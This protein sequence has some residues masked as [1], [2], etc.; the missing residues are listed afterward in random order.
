VAAGLSLGGC[1]DETTT[2]TTP[3]PKADGPKELKRPPHPNMATPAWGEK[4]LE[5]LA[6]KAPEDLTEKGHQGA[7]DAALAQLHAID[8]DSEVL[9]RNAAVAAWRTAMDDASKGVSSALAAAAM[10]LEPTLDG[11]Q[12]RLT[13]AHGIAAYAGTL[14]ST[15]VVGQAA[16]GVVAVATGRIETGRKLL[17]RIA[18]NAEQDKIDAETHLLLAQGY[19]LLGERSDVFFEQLAHAQKK[20]PDSPRAR[21]LRVRALGEMGVLDDI[22]TLQALDKRT[23]REDALLGRL[24]T[25]H[26]DVDAGKKL[27]RAAQDKVP[28]AERGE[29]LFWL[30]MALKDDP[31]EGKQATAIV[32]KLNVMQGYRGEALLLNAHLAMQKGDYANAQKS[33]DMLTKRPG[34]TKAIGTEAAWLLVDACAALGDVKCVKEKGRTAVFLDG[35]RA[36]LAHAWAALSLV[37]KV[38]KLPSGG[39]LNPKPH[40]LQAHMLSPFDP[41]LARLV[42]KPVVDG[43]AKAAARLRA[44]RAL[45]AAGARAEAKRVLSTPQLAFNQACGACRAL[46]AIAEP[47]QREAAELALKALHNGRQAPIAEADAM[48]LVE[49]LLRSGMPKARD[50]LKRMAKKHPSKRVRRAAVDALSGASADPHGMPKTPGMGMPGGGHDHQH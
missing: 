33:A 19:F 29:L 35:N 14:P 1:G 10:V 44:A 9:M 45:L 16:R 24:L 39:R 12:E 8:A 36:R 17:D 34:V 11:Y 13:D 48:A 23:P 38:K 3:P 46:L 49:V 43:G 22:K 4:A 28:E 47:Q 2:T 25:L 20:R 41:D 27:L 7:L 31:I 32:D 21:L 42:G 37:G 6:D 5:Q 50:E 15:T 40:Q 26:G 30:G 18:D